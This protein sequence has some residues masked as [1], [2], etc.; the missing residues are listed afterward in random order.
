VLAKDDEV[1]I[2]PPAQKSNSSTIRRPKG[3]AVNKDILLEHRLTVDEMNSH[4]VEKDGIY[5]D[6]L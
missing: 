5:G 6:H 1:L 2:N 3:N 4:L